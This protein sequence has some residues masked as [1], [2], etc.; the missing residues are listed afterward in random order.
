M[1]AEITDAQADALYA[2]RARR[3]QERRR[4]VQV[5]LEETDIA[6]TLP[7]LTIYVCGSLG[8]DEA[9]ANSDLDLFQIIDDTDAGVAKVTRLQKFDL[10]AQIILTHRRLG[11][12]DPSKDGEYLVVH[13]LNDMLKGLGGRDED[14]Y[15]AFTARMLML[16]ESKVALNE[17]IY[18]RV[19][20][21]IVQAYFRDY[22]DHSDAFRPI[23]L[24]NDI[25]R[26]WKTLNLNYENRRTPDQ[27][28]STD[29]DKISDARKNVKL[30]FSRLL[31][32]WSMVLPLASGNY[33]T[34]DD[35]LKLVK[36]SPRERLDDVATSSPEAERLVR[37]LK[38]Q[39]AQ[40]L[41]LDSDD[42]VK[43]SLAKREAR[44][45]VFALGNKFAEG[46][47]KLLNVSADKQV[48][49]YVIV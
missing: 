11:F 2:E 19:V 42:E 39:Y 35:I 37:Q 27:A 29:E 25:L 24:L 12:P 43:A 14:Y 3:S 9:A 5:S 46:V 13:S 44:E 49:R 21:L 22:Q 16:L 40:F 1:V 20:K 15:N 4:A 45:E 32:C 17:A 38:T 41:Q 6:R 10:Y 31:I 18:D 28:A 48:L 8:R 7:N 33:D 26:Y 34:A 23:F 47:L 30:K 36:K